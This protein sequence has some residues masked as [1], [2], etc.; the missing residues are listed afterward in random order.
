MIPVARLWH[1]KGKNEYFSIK[2]LMNTFPNTSFEFHIVLNEPDYSDEWSNKIDE[3]QLDITYYSKEYMADY[4]KIAYP[5]LSSIVDKFPNFIHFYHILIGH[6]LRRVLLKDYMLTYEFDVIFNGELPFVEQLIQSK[7]PFGVS[8]PSNPG[9]DKAL[10]SNLSQIFQTDL[11]KRMQ[12]NNP[13]FAGINAG[14]Q[15]VNLSLFDSFLSISHLGALLTIFN[16]NGILKEDGTELWGPDRM[17]FDTQEQSFY[18]IM[19]QVFSPTFIVL[20]QTEYYFSPCWEDF[21]GYIE[22]AMKSKI[23]HFTGHK[24]A[25][26][27]YDIIESGVQND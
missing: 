22:H 5:P 3:L 24:K 12:N 7:T 1:R 8:E 11:A 14:F 18:S 17:V 15:G 27:L 2:Q 21:D 10:L 13:S 25:K 19:N 26:L 20:P 9:C 4:F 6:Y 23:V 16:F